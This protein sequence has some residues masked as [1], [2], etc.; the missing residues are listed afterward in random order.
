MAEDAPE[1]IGFNR[2]DADQLLKK[3]GV[4]GVT[5]KRSLVS[6]NDAT[7]LRIAYTAG[8]ITARSGSTVGTG[9]A[10]LRYVDNSDV[11]QTESPDRTVTVKNLAATAVGSA[12]YIMVMRVGNKWFVVWEEC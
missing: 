10:S 7:Q 5:P 11:L 6:I 4:N 1:V 12:K 9:S 8:G 3:I 2:D